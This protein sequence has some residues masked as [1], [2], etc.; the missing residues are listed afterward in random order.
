M[1][2]VVLRILDANL[3]RAREGLRVVEEHARMVLNDAGLTSRIKNLRHD[4]AVVAESIGPL[5]MLAARDT[6]G[7]VGTQISTAAEQHRD[8]PAHV[9]AAAAKRVAEALRCVE[10]YAKTEYAKTGHVQAAAHAEK[11]R[12]DLYTIEQELLLTG[13]RRKRLPEARL[14]VLVTASLCRGDW[15]EVCKKAMA[16]GADVLQLREKQLPDGELLERARLLRELTAAHGALLFINDR[17]DIARLVGADGV[18]VGRHDLPVA[19][20]RRIAGPTVLIGKSAH[21]VAEAR[22]ALAESPDYIAVGPMFRS[23]TKPE[24]PVQGPSLLAD[25]AALTVIPL[26][27]IGGIAPHNVAQLRSPRPFAIAAS[28]AVISA[29][30]PAAAAA[31]LL[32][33]NPAKPLIK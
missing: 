31:S 24:V 32:T 8:G 27:A 14:H 4:L 28:S 7:D 13:P 2:P 33:A 16:G 5:P 12:Y 6:P 22:A 23:P 18:H 19:E 15:L 25:V 11:L 10:E 20:A 30:D 3:N 1:D 17:A 26:V 21:S 29:A 9:A